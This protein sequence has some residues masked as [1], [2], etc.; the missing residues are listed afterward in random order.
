[1]SSTTGVKLTPDI[2]QGLVN[3]CLIHKF[4]AA[5]ESPEC[6]KEWWE[7]CCSPHPNVAIAAPRGH[8]KSTAITF[9]YTLACILFRVRDFAMIVSATETQS[10][11]FLG[12]I[13]K[14]LAENDDIHALFGKIVLIKDSETDTIGQFADGTQFRILAK[15]AEQKLR[16]LKWDSKRPN[17]IVIDDL[18][19]DEA[20]MN[21]D[22]RDK[23][24]RWFVGA[25][26]PS[27]SAT[28]LVR[29]VGTILHMD[30]LLEN[31][32]PKEHDRKYTHS[33]PIKVWSTDT[34]RPWLAV[35]YRAHSPDYSLLLWESKFN[36]EHWIRT[37][38]EY[39]YQGTLDMYSQEYLN[40]PLDESNAFFKKQD[41]IPISDQSLRRISEHP[42]EYTF[43]AASDFA[44]TEKEKSDYS[45]FVVSAVDASGM[46]YIVDV[47]RERTD[48]LAIIEIMFQIQQKY[49]PELFTV[50][51][52][53]IEK[54]LG[55]VLRQEMMK[56]NVYINLN[57]MVPTKDK[58]SRARSFQARLRSGGVRFYKDSEWYD[59]YESE[60]LRFPRDKHDDQ[61][62]AT[63]WLGLTLDKVIEGKSE[64]EINDE[65][66]EDE[67][68][69]ARSYGSFGDGRCQSTG[70]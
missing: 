61:V 44:I 42:R 69:Q 64:E 35:K 17:L 26:L 66:Y 5:T 10:V 40:N 7:L 2:I 4:D 33:T 31:L 62:D 12:D 3:T 25:L 23:M 20:V 34:R 14:E 39:R 53:A 45:V 41:F 67:L 63:A 22:R 1:M 51:A 59:D 56:R 50:E 9:A 27:R 36:K 52:G 47:I 60:L 8:A 48:S 32:M 65:D 46:M 49:Q 70:Y 24:K 57:P 29:Y 43:Y 13:K 6:H 37:K 16:G 38:E 28:G 30:S 19:D 54:S 68:E 11:L 21:K 58:I 18:E 55:P 15:G